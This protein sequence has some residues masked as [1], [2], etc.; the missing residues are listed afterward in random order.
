MPP[1][2]RPSDWGRWWEEFFPEASPVEHRDAYVEEILSDDE[3]ESDSDGIVVRRSRA[4]QSHLESAALKI[5]RAKRQGNSN[6]IL[7]HGEID[8]LVRT[9]LMRDPR[10][11]EV[12]RRRVSLSAYS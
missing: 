3:P 6:V 12:E 8:A 9:S 1:W 10:K 7:T 11:A 4:P 5:R 2:G